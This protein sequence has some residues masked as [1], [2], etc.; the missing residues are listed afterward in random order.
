M[1]SSAKTNFAGCCI[2]LAAV[3]GRLAQISRIEIDG[4]PN[5]PLCPIVDLTNA[6]TE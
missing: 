5:N 6:H 4:C 2:E 3:S 1:I